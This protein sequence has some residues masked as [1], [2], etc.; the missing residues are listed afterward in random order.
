MKV[1]NSHVRTYDLLIKAEKTEAHIPAQWR[2]R[3]YGH[4]CLC[5]TGRFLNMMSFAILK[6][7]PASGS[8][9]SYYSGSPE[10]HYIK[11]YMFTGMVELCGGFQIIFSSGERW[12]LVKCWTLCRWKTM[13]GSQSLWGQGSD[14]SHNHFNFA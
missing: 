5:L 12:N 9:L 4:L 10:E 14:V 7:N 8:L 1:A 2:Q 11:V 6:Q 3:E 13:G